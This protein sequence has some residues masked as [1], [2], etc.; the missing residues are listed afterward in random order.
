M[1]CALN[2]I[3]SPRGFFFPDW[4]PHSWAAAKESFVQCRACLNHTAATVHLHCRS[5]RNHHCASG[6]CSLT[7]PLALSETSSVVL[8]WCSFFLL[9]LQFTARISSFYDEISA[10]IEAALTPYPLDIHP[11]KRC[12]LF[13]QKRLRWA[14]AGWWCLEIDCCRADYA[15]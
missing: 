12:R 2:L 9:T 1:K 10:V 3:V 6:I 15:I 14:Y 4:W 7:W 8:A 11:R 5:N 13:H